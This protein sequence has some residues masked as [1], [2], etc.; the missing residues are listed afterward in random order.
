MNHKFRK[1]II[2]KPVETETASGARETVWTEDGD[3]YI[4]IYRRDELNRREPFRNKEMTHI[5][6]S[7]D[8]IN[9]RGYRVESEGV[10]YDVLECNPDGRYKVYILRA[11]D[12]W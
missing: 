3:A 11:V 10:V 7:Y 2:K 5:G 9:K 6:L 4:A 1:A 12:K 8:T